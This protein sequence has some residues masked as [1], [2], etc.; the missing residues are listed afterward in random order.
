M[1]PAAGGANDGLAELPAARVIDR[2]FVVILALA[3]FAR[4]SLLPFLAHL[5]LAGDEAYYWGYLDLL[6][7]RDADQLVLRPPLWGHVVAFLRWIFGSPLACR[8]ATAV[9]GA[10]T[11]PAVYLLGRR[12]FDRRT[13]IVAGVAFAFYPEFLG[14]SHYLWAEVLL[15]LLCV[16]SVL[17]VFRFLDEPRR[18]GFLYA[19]AATAG[20]ALL[21]KALAVLVFA[22]LIATL[23]AS[24]VPRKALRGLAASLLFFL[25]ATLYSIHATSLAGRTVL[26]GQTGLMSMRQA[27]RLDSGTVYDPQNREERTAELVRHLRQ[28][29]LDVAIDDVTHQ[30][31]NLWDPTSFVAVRLLSRVGEEHAEWQYGVS[32]PTARALTVVVTGAYFLLVVLGMVGLCLDDWTPFKTFAVVTL[33]GL[34]CTTLALRL[35]SRYRMSFL[36]ILLL[37]AVHAALRSREVFPRV[38]RPLRAAPLALL[39][40]LFVEISVARIAHVGLW[41]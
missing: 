23:L 27:V 1:A 8:A 7:Q 11:A 24:R 38:L 6:R 40:W 28:R 25:P 26:L 3:L 2:P 35:T 13:G 19:G 22:G 5:Q 16:L 12:A 33:S 30:F 20:L 39:L 10:C 41:G 15:T 37:F 36:F 14:Y 18:A 9:L 17:F 34:C 31:Y 32:R 4:L 29:P 21:T